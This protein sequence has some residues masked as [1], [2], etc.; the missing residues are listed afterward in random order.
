M[1]DNFI[2]GGVVIDVREEHEWNVKHVE[3]AILLPLGDFES[4]IKEVVPDKNTPIN[5]YC[6][7]G[8]RSG[9]AKNI[10]VDLGYT[11]VANLGGVETAIEKVPK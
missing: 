2:S 3:G 5:V 6:R 7:S 4:K 10:A 11:K 9:S 8:V 1:F